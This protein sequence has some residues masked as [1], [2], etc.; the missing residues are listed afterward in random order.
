[1]QRYTQCVYCHRSTRLRETGS[2]RGIV[3]TM[4]KHRRGDGLWCEGGGQFPPPENPLTPPKKPGRAECPVCHR[5]TATRYRTGELYRHLDW[6]TGLICDGS[7]QA[8]QTDDDNTTVGITGGAGG[9]WGYGNSDDDDQPK[10][11]VEILTD[12]WVQKARTEAD[13]VCAKAIDYGAT[14]LRDLGYQ[15]LEMA[16][17]RPN[18]DRYDGDQE[19]W[20]GYATEV[21][22]VFYAQGKLARIVAAIKEGRRP[23]VDSWLDLGVYARMAQRVHEAGGW[24]AV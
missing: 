16:G 12:W 23:N 14:D 13:M 19:Y 18:P 6:H 2:G 7:G 22:I 4:W 24:P 15:V 10:H 21:G 17:R 5:D 8:T 3:G 11:P 9:F 20:D 1:M